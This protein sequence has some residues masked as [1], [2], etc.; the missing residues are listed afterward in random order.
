MGK[1]SSTWNEIPSFPLVPNSTP[2]H[3]EP[4]SCVVVVRGIGGGRESG[5]ILLR[6]S[7]LLDLSGYLCCPSPPVPSVCQSINKAK[8]SNSQCADCRANLGVEKSALEKPIPTANPPPTHTYRIAHP[9]RVGGVGYLLRTYI[10]CLGTCPKS[11]FDG[12]TA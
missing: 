5:L 1:K 10:R 7:S 12:G 3:F 6:S 2:V 11:L 4:L 8:S 9:R